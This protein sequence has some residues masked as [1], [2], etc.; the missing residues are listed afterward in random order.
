MKS[1]LS[2]FLIIGLIGGLSCFTAQAQKFGYVDAEYILSQLPSYQKA[3]QEIGQ[4]AGRWQ[5][6]IEGKFQAVEK[7][8]ADY[9][10]EEPMLTDEMKQERQE[11]I[12]ALMR[13]ASEYQKKIFGYQGLYFSRKQ[14]LIKPALEELNEAVQKVARKERLEFIFTNTE[15]L[16]ILYA[17]PRHDYTKKVLEELGLLKDEENPEKR[18]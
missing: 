5:E 3:Q 7:L 14:E 1:Y 8:Q 6:D 18:D 12:K 15:G 9:Y 4:D 10:A 11:E 17:E 16:T 13:Q 2:A